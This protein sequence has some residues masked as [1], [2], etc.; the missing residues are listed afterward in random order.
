MAVVLRSVQMITDHRCSR[1]DQGKDLLRRGIRQIDAAVGTS[2][3]V[4]HA[5]EPAP[6][7]RIVE[8]DPPVKRHPEGYRSGITHAAQNRPSLHIFHIIHPGRRPMSRRQISG[9]GI[10]LKDHL[11]FL[12]HQHMLRCQI[13]FHISISIIAL[14]IASSLLQIHRRPCGHTSLADLTAQFPDLPVHIHLPSKIS[15]LYG[16]GHS[17][18]GRKGMSAPQRVILIRQLLDILSDLLSGQCHGS[19]FAYP[20]PAVDHPG[21]HHFFCGS[22]LIGNDGI[23]HGIG[24]F[25]GSLQHRIFA[26]ALRRF[27]ASHLIQYHFLLAGADRI[28]QHLTGRPGIQKTAQFLRNDLIARS[29]LICTQ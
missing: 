22:E 24:L 8:S 29:L 18:T 23:H 14:S 16:R 10:C 5:S 25:A 15:A 17:V 7:R 1:R 11:P 13:D 27:I 9:D 19:V 2:G 3:L 12:I 6:P 26:G 28:R 4:D 20:D 21:I